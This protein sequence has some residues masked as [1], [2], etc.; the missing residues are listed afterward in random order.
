MEDVLVEEAVI[1]LEESYS[2][3]DHLKSCPIFT[4]RNEIVTFSTAF[5]SSGTLK[6]LEYD[7]EGNLKKPE[8]YHKVDSAVE[9][10]EAE[11]TETENASSTEDG[12]D[13]KSEKMDVDELGNEEVK[14]LSVEQDEVSEDS[15]EDMDV[16]DSIRKTPKKKDKIENE[17]EKQ[18]SS[19]VTRKPLTLNDF[20]S[21]T[22]RHIEAREISLNELLEL[23]EMMVFGEEKDGDDGGEDEEGISDV[24]HIKVKD[25]SSDNDNDS[26]ILYSSGEADG[27]D[28]S[29][30]SSIVCFEDET[31]QK[32]Q[33]DN[34]T[35]SSIK[36]TTIASSDKVIH[37]AEEGDKTEKDEDKEKQ[38]DSES[39]VEFGGS[40]WLNDYIDEFEN[41]AEGGDN[42][43]E[44][45]E[46][47]EDDVV[48]DVN[49]DEFTKTKLSNYLQHIRP[50]TWDMDVASLTCEKCGSVTTSVD[51]LFSHLETND[52]CMNMYRMFESAS[53]ARNP[54]M[55][56][57]EEE[58]PFMEVF[59]CYA[60]SYVSYD[61]TEIQKHWLKEHVEEAMYLCR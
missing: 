50:L 5:L 27:K 28:N 38:S 6:P 61:S 39:D 12:Y 26:K 18:S 55:E 59:G 25:D 54:P 49:E 43:K 16:N 23:N 41:E 42:E 56:R 17:S 47:E 15:E 34:N 57:D 51:L 19:K 58:E 1:E 20:G 3:S 40:A 29:I 37:A 13:G 10:D 22:K 7:D 44:V 36:S 48:D 24:V 60:C 52:E 53:F 30:D 35:N 11:N 4:Q 8:S 32:D 21:L 14:S 31:K 33:S 2:L 45:K 9:Q 46:E